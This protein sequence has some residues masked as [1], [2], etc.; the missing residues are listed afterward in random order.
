MSSVVI[1]Y[2]LEGNTKVAALELALLLGADVF[3]IKTIKSYPTFKL[4]KIITGGYEATFGLKP[5]IEPMPIDLA[6]YDLV[7]LALPVWA[8]KPA[9][10]ML[11]FLDE[12]DV[13]GKQLA[14]L[15]T[16]GSG[17]GQ[18]CVEALAQR[19]G[20]AADSLP[21]L[22]LREPRK[23]AEDERADQI[24]SF[25]VQLASKEVS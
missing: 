18:S 11:S 10:P 20:V 22:S 1:Y 24:H 17:D 8:G 15:V 4:G 5:W 19:L 2:S 6:N 25:A 9:S 7:I 16:S 3:E 23:L 21:V 13:T 12:H 14:L